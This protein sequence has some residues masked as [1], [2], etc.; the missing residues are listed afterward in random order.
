MFFIFIVTDIVLD[1]AALKKEYTFLYFQIQ[2]YFATNTK[3]YFNGNKNHIDIIIVSSL[4][5][6]ESG[7]CKGKTPSSVL[8]FKEF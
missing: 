7:C 8:S 3:V 1:I 4:F 2:V 5:E 6:V